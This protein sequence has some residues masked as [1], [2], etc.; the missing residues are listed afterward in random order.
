M[1]IRIRYYAS[2]RE[3][4]GTSSEELDLEE[5]SRVG[6]LMRVIMGLHE[7]LKGLKGILIAVNGEYVEMDEELREGDLVA[8]FP[9]LSGG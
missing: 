1:R 6:D 3:L 7:A 2:L 4:I 8:L 9:P 5:G